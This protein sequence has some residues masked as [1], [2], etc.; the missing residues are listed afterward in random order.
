MTAMEQLLADAGA[1][2]REARR[3]FDV[4]AGLRRLAEDAGYVG[5][6][7]SVRRSS[8]ARRRLSAVARWSLTQ[9]SA[10]D[11]VERLTSE[12]GEE[13]GEV[14]RA[15]LKDLD[16]EGAQVFACLL[17]L[18]DHPESAQFWWQ[19]A[20]GAGHLRAAYCLHL[21]HLSLGEMREAAF[22]EGQLPHA[23]DGPGE[24]QSTGHGFTHAIPAP[25]P[26]GLRDELERLAT[27][28]DVGVLVCRPD[29]RLADRLQDLTGRR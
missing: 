26:S 8:R 21:H 6:G 18:S 27:D 17:Y 23:P 3:P 14:T 2:V 25:V 19:L 9:P 16:V 13:G 11:H 4:A 22:W 24:I 29:R 7:S 10:L 5:P 12:I 1:A 20:A 15:P 28:G